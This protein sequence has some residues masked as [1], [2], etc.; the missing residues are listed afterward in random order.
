M[1]GEIIELI[2]PGQPK[3][4]KRHRTGKGGQ[5]YDPS[6]ADKGMLRRWMLKI[7]PATPIDYPVIIE[8]DAFFQT[9]TSWSEAKKERY[10]G[11][12]RAK[13]PDSDNVEKIIFDSMN[14]YIVED[15]KLIVDNHTRRFYSVKPCTHIRLRPAPFDSVAPEFKPKQ[16]QIIP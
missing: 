1:A 13:T 7:K 12:Y 6:K 10:E 16:K 9:P 2:I 5:R 3:A 11:K 4:Q 14:K 15:D 8:I